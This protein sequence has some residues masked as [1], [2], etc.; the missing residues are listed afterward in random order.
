MCQRPG[1]RYTQVAVLACRRKNKRSLGVNTPAFLLPALSWPRPSC[2]CRRWHHQPCDLACCPRCV[3]IRLPPPLPF[4]LNSSLLRK[5]LRLRPQGH[6][7]GSVYATRGRRHP[8]NRFCSII[9]NACPGLQVSAAIKRAEEAQAKADIA[10][11]EQ[12]RLRTALKDA[13]IDLQR[14]L[15]ACALHEEAAAAAGAVAQHLLSDVADISAE[16][17]DG[18]SSQRISRKFVCMATADMLVSYK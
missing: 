8:R 6:A 5:G 9:P 10:T 15:S 11:A 4:S 13:E 18:L 1:V 17:R 16:V 3:A 7:P 12:M 2:C 14:A